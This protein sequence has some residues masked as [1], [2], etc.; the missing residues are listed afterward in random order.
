MKPCNHHVGHISGV[1]HT[2]ETWGDA[3]QDIERR[4]H[5]FNTIG[6]RKELPHPGWMIPFK[7]CPKC[8]EKIDWEGLNFKPLSITNGIN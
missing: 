8:G 3:V 2:K 1:V 6:Q 7:F 5:E 4:I